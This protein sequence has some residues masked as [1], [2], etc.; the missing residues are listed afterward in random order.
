MLP[1]VTAV[2]LKYKEVKLELL[3]M[4][5]EVGIAPCIIL[6]LLIQKHSLPSSIKLPPLKKEIWYFNKYTIL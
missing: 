5:N 3:E 2:F 1:F 4:L 6:I